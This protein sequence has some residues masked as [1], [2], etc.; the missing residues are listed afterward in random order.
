MEAKEIL[1]EIAERE[2]FI[3]IGRGVSRFDALDKA[4]GRARFTADYVERDALVVKVVRSS[5]PPRPHQR[6]QNR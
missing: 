6:H 2:E 1:E 4:L 3:V 5:L